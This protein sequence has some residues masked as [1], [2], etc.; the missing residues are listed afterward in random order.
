MAQ[1]LFNITDPISSNDQYPTSLVVARDD[2]RRLKALCGRAST[3]VTLALRDRIEGQQEQHL[4]SVLEVLRRMES[5]LGLY[6]G[7]GPKVEQATEDGEGAGGDMLS[8]GMQ[9]SVHHGKVD[10]KTYGWKRRPNISAQV[11]KV[12]VEDDKERRVEEHKS[13]AKNMQRMQDMSEELDRRAG[14]EH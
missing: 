9:E 2:F 1:Q 12:E 6:D 7:E 11:D 14:V 8:G 4:D 3:T 5:I 10:G 13:F